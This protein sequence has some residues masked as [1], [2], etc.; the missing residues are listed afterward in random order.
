M[1]KKIKLLRPYF[2]M[3]TNFTL[4]NLKMEYLLQFFPV[5]LLKISYTIDFQMFY[6]DKLDFKIKFLVS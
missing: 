5:F 6:H 1:K 4:I 2:T 3:R